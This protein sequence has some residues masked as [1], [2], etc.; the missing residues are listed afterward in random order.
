VCEKTR[1][2]RVINERREEQRKWEHAARED[3]KG[4]RKRRDGGREREI[5]RERE[6]KTEFEKTLAR[7]KKSREGEGKERYT[8]DEERWPRRC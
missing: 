1:R 8:K 3:R 2:E 7:D 6:T 4:E 5:E